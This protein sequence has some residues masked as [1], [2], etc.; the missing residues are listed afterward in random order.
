MKKKLDSEEAEASR[1]TTS[2]LTELIT[3]DGVIQYNKR[4]IKELPSFVS[5]L[6]ANI[7]VPLACKHIYYNYEFL[8]ALFVCCSITEVFDNLNKINETSSYNM[9]KESSAASKEVK[10]LSQVYLQC[11]ISVSDFP[12]SLALQVLSRSLIF[13]GFSSYLTEFINQ[14]DR[15]SKNHCALV[16]CYQSLPPIGM[17]AL[18]T[19]ERHTKP[20][21][22]TIVGGDNDFF[23]ITLS[24][25]IHAFNMS[26]LGDMG[27]IQLPKLNDSD[28]Y[29]QMLVHFIEKPDN[30]CKSLNLINGLVVVSSD[31]NLHSINFDSS[32]NFSKIFE[33]VKI[34]KIMQISQN[35]VLV[36]FEDA[37]YFEVY[38]FY[39]G[40]MVLIQNFD[41]KIKFME[42]D[43]KLDAIYLPE[44]FNNAIKL[45]VV[46]ENSEINYFKIEN[47]IEKNDKRNNAVAIL[48]NYTFKSPGIDCVSCVYKE[49]AWDSKHSVFCF[50]FRDG[51][52]I[53]DYSNEKIVLEA[54]KPNIKESN[55][56]GT[57]IQMTL[58]NYQNKYSNSE[59]LF[60]SENGSLYFYTI[61]LDTKKT[62]FFKVGGIYS[63]AYFSEKNKI[64]GLNKG[65]LDFYQINFNNDVYAGILLLS[66]DVHFMDITRVYFKGLCNILGT[67]IFRIK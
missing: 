14:S 41:F 30:S 35:H 47:K 19:L 49:D 31:Y 28:I 1:N 64:I 43:I 12:D 3:E 25:K 6:T 61:H 46:Y 23:V 57:Y 66:V 32:L 8:H 16:A 60:I 15:Y 27:E 45:V 50:S 11:G 51:S 9:S 22:F 42:I 56:N 58:T 17:G 21:Y 29:K 39:N 20:I 63:K 26:L 44:Y 34:K 2:Q 59:F 10:F 40:D 36:C 38:N 62:Y 67:L 18:F 5:M 54:F 53:F 37:K 13:Y 24:N 33:N 52:F 65:G 4:K 55:K 7:S 48:C